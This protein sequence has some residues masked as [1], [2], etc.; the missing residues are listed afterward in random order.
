[1]EGVKPRGLRPD[2]GTY[3][4]VT[5][6]PPPPPPPPPVASYPS[7]HDANR[8]RACE[9]PVADHPLPRH[10]APPLESHHS[11]SPPPP[12]PHPN[13]P[14]PT[15]LGLLPPPP[16]LGLAAF[17]QTNRADEQEARPI[18]SQ[19]LDRG[20]RLML[21]RR[22]RL[23]PLPLGGR[24]PWTGGASPEPL[25]PPPPPS[26]PIPQIQKSGWWAR[27]CVDGLLMRGKVNERGRME[28]S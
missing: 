11:K 26:P 25:R 22:R 6:P 8:P 16:P 2:V 18:T 4:V 12:P 21:G 28:E 13:P 27:A 7:S 9:H 19:L 17:P 23:V 1:M 10:N 24:E 5:T 3:L 20:R 14:P 15:S